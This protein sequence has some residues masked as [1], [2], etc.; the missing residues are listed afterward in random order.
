MLKVDLHIHSNHSNDGE[1]GVPEILDKCIQCKLD[2]ISITDHNT[3]RGVQE[4]LEYASDKGLK[5]LAGIEID[6]IYEGIDLHLLGY[7]IDHLSSDFTRLIKEYEDRVMDSVPRMIRNLARAGIAVDEEE[8]ME[9]AGSGLPSPELI[10]EV[11]L[12]NTRYHHN[13]LLDPYR[14]GGERSDM[15]Y[16]NFYLDYFAQGKPAYDKIE[17]ISY[18]EAVELVVRNGGIPV[19]AHPG[20]NL[21]GQET[22]ITGLLDRGAGGLEVFNNYHDQD[23]IIYFCETGM[24]RKALMTCGS[25]FHGKNKPLIQPGKYRVDKHYLEYINQS[26]KELMKGLAG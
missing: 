22:L 18:E 8:V 19:V 15:P 26:T 16:I 5:V 4:A 25:D 11:L 6:C 13:G 20:A 9:K 10:A 14:P 1:F 21:R 24:Q 7:N 17:H 2:V 12:T 3:V 23:Q